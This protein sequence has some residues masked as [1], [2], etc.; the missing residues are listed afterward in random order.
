MDSRSGRRRIRR[1]RVTRSRGLCVASA[2]DP[3]VDV[4]LAPAD[5]T[6][7]NPKRLG[8][9]PAAPHTPQGRLRNAQPGDDLRLPHD[10]VPCFRVLGRRHDEITRGSTQSARWTRIP[11]RTRRQGPWCRDGDGIERRAH[12]AKWASPSPAG[13]DL[14]VVAAAVEARASERTAEAARSP[15]VRPRPPRRGGG[16]GSG[17]YTVARRCRARPLGRE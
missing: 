9:I 12:G 4:G 16:R 11:R 1:T 7:A 14:K 5:Q 8:E 2:L 17:S 15:A 3:A 13:V 6:S 10:A